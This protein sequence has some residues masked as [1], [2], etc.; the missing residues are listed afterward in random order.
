MLEDPQVQK[1][2]R[3]A[4]AE[5]LPYPGGIEVLSEAMV[6]FDG[7]DVLRI[8][9]V[10]S[11]QTAKSIAGDQAMKLITEIRDSLLRE[12]DERFPL[13]YYATPEDLLHADDPDDES[14]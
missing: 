10:L 2:M 3:Q 4:L 14:D 5:V 12:G 7:R 6:D 9:L 13:I 1:L 11:E 8:T